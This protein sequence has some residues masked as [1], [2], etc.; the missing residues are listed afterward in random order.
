MASVRST[1]SQLVVVHDCIQSILDRG[2]P[3]D[4]ILIDLLK[5]FDRISLRKLI[6]C[7]EIYGIKGQLKIGSQRTWMIEK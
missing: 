2:I 3:I 6:H 5:A 7:L 4:I 1:V